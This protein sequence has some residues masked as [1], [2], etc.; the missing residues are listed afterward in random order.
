MFYLQQFNFLPEPMPEDMY[1]YNLET[2]KLFSHT[3]LWKFE[4]LRMLIGTD[5]PIFKSANNN[6]CLSLRLR[7]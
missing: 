2:N 1:P 7:Y 5:L 3:F 6:S 4:G